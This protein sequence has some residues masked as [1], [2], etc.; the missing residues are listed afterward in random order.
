M[1]GAEWN[2][3]MHYGSR[4]NLVFDAIDGISR[5]RS[6][7]PLAPMFRHA[8][9]K[10]G[11]ASLGI[12]D[13]PRPGAG[14]NPII[15]TES[16]PPGFR[17]CYIK[18]RFYLV[19]HICARARMAREPFRYSEAP[20]P[21]AQ[22]ASHQRFMQALDTFGM[23]KG[24]IVPLGRSTDIPACVWLAGKDPILDDEA[25]RSIQLIALFAAS[26]ARVLS[27]PHDTDTR[28]R[29]LTSREREVLTW[30]AQGKPAWE[31]GQI[32]HIAKRTVDEHTQTAM[33]KLGT[34]NRTHAVAVALRHH[35][36]TL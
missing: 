32:L 35:M 23:S 22:A 25:K 1:L 30:A 36:I 5:L 28:P 9:A 13:L 6:L 19:D 3:W 10:W 18:E 21:R 27:L 8:V 4:R 20:Y 2:F 24:L 31:I 26:M 7:P 12:N 14:A 16:T 29:E 33:R 15:L 17:E 34:A 11:F